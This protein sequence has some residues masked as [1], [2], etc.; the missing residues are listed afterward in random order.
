[1][2]ISDPVHGFIEV[3]QGLLTRLVKHPLF[4]R[5]S[6]I[7]QLGPT[8]YV[9]PGA[10]HTRFEHSLGA[11]HLATKAIDSLKEKGNILLP[12]EE[13][14]LRI[15]MLLHD[16]G[17]GPMS[18]A[19]EE[20]LV[21]GISHEDI[22]VL[23]MEQLNDETDGQLET[24]IKIFTDKY[25][26]IYLSELIHSQLDMDRMDYLCRDSFFTGVREGNIG[27]DRII[28]MLNVRADRLV[29]DWKGI[30]TIENYLMSRRLMY[31][32]VYLHKTVMAAKELLVVA[33]RRAQQLARSGKE[34]YASPDLAYFLHNRVDKKFA[35]AHP[36]WIQHYTQLDDGDLE[37]AMKQWQHSGDKVLGL[38]ASDYINRNLYKVVEP[39]QAVSAGNLQSMR[40]KMASILGIT[41]EE[42]AF[43][44]R[45][46]EVHQELYSSA[47]DHIFIRF[48][49][50][51]TN[52]IAE[53]SEL[54]GSEMVDKVDHRNFLFYQRCGEQFA[55]EI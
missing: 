31:W 23:L 20:V 29:V 8:N 33:L 49:D 54:L 27:A 52:D 5:L 40:T 43:F 37:S 53:V 44:V 15:A 17:H 41:P 28:K 19:L 30:Y 55:P 3:P 10:R 26:H 9:Y 25:P 34:V 36:E 1:M 12:Q 38:L 46:T 7:K 14:G 39:R 50:D 13:E 24:A 18:H 6:R 32:Q 2:I 42:A 35:Q 48:K 47:D 51:S 45:T 4:F 16:I 11:Y 21:E 22:T